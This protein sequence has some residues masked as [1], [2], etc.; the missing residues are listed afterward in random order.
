MSLPLRYPADGGGVLDGQSQLTI[1][2]VKASLIGALEAGARDCLLKSE[3]P[4]DL[5]ES[6]AQLITGG[7]PISPAIASH[8]LQRFKPPSMPAT[9]TLTEPPSRHTATSHVRSIH[10]KLEVRSRSEAIYEALSR[11]IITVPERP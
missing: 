3:S 11:G 10:R 9:R 2:V 6:V 4:A 7:A 8:L 1:L 5:R